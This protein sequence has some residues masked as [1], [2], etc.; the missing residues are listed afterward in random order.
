MTIWSE[1]IA[2]CNRA[3]RVIHKL[4]NSVILPS[5][6]SASL[7]VS[8]QGT[9]QSGENVTLTCDVSSNGAKVYSFYKKNAVV[10]TGGYNEYFLPST[11]RL[12]SGDY[13]CVVHVSGF[14]S[15]RSSSQTVTVGG[16]SSIA[17]VELLMDRF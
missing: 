1:K 8:H 4:F 15:G 7:S 9:I 2:P 12:D 16:E 11:T 17:V 6:A 13:S 10:Q 14:Q 5:P 3:I